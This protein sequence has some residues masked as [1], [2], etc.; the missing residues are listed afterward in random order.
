M[1]KMFFAAMTFAALLTFN[2]CDLIDNLDDNG[3]G[4]PFATT[5]NT[6][7]DFS[8]CEEDMDISFDD[9]PDAVV[10]Y[11]EE[12][13]AGY[14]LDDVD[15]YMQNGGERFGVDIYYQ[16]EE[17]ELLFAADGTLISSGTDTDDVI[18]DAGQL[19]QA[20]LD[21]LDTEF[22]N[23][24]IEEVEIEVEYGLEFY[25][26]DLSNGIDVYFTADGTFA[27]SED[28][29]NSD[30]GGDDDDGDDDDNIDLP[31]AAASFIQDNFPDYAIDYV[32]R[33]EFCN[34][35]IIEVEIEMGTTDR[36]LYFD[37]NGD[38]LFEADD[39]SVSTLPQAVAAT[40]EVEYP[41]FQID[42]AEILTMADGSTRYWV[43]V[44]N[45]TNDNEK[46][47]DVI[48]EEDGSIVCSFED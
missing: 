23:A 47:Y 39:I 9:L 41:D 5:F 32:Q 27:C 31:S 11:L 10:N 29:D 38:F 4:N 17:L 26:L 18:V 16:G 44:E 21:Y 6:D 2:S 22:P 3:S 33:E 25:D 1:K 19:P 42:D 40:L 20:V 36:D 35:Y 34:G 12:N 7:L 43:E 24:A 15:R 8:P 30:D 48:L 13:Y 37:L 46:E 14:T 45:E 28:D